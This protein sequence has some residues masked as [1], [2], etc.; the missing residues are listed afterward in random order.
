[1]RP[2]IGHG[3]HEPATVDGGR[4]GPPGYGFAVLA[5]RS[6]A[7]PG[8]G[9]KL[10]PREA[11]DALP[12]GSDRNDSA[13]AVEPALSAAAIRRLVAYSRLS[14]RRS[15]QTLLKMIDSIP[16]GKAADFKPLRVD[17]GLQMPDLD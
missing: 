15:G 6:D 3:R 8:P 10:I 4:T 11:C 13:S 7:H 1:M 14:S 5:S 9:P 17:I 2:R 16:G 12:E